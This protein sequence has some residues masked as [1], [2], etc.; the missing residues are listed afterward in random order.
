MTENEEFI[1][2]SAI[3][4]VRMRFLSIEDIKH[5]IIEEIEDNGFEEEIS[6]EWAFEQ[7]ENEWIKLKIESEHWESPTDTNR[8]I[9]AFDELCSK[10]II[11]LHNAGY[12]TSDGE[13]EV[14]GVEAELRNE[15]I[16]SDGYC[17][18]H[19]QDLLRA[20]ENENP[21]LYLAFQKV[22][23]EDDQVT[24]EVGRKI[25]KILKKHGFTVEWNEEVTNRILILDFR[26]Q[27]IYSDTNRNLLDYN[28]VVK[29][30]SLLDRK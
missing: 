28:E 26:W 4:R 18:Y 30:M 19:E 8:L 15:G 5:K 11:A 3:S 22:D 14:I 16:V 27:Y 20:I 24:I 21:N 23:N 25:I 13:S 17:F 7:I 2:E 1:Y 10:N 9:E 12:D 6:K 29:L